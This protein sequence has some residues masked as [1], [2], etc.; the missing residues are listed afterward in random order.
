MLL[1]YKL[2]FILSGCSNPI[3]LEDGRV[4]D[5]QLSANHGGQMVFK[6]RLNYHEGGWCSHI[7]DNKSVFLQIA[8]KNVQHISGI[9][10]QGVPD[11]DSSFEG[12][13]KTFEVQYGYDGTKWYTYEG[14]GGSVQVS[15]IICLNLFLVLRFDGRFGGHFYQ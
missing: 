8:L 1:N 15:S 10:T 7:N 13:V 6:A 3:G 11:H 4:H 9:A 5:S 12:Y 2:A 14:S